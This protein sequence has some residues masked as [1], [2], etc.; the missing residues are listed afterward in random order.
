VGELQYVEVL[1]SHL[2]QSKGC[3]VVEF[4]YGDDARYAIHKFNEIVF[5]GRPIFVREDREQD[6]GLD[7]YERHQHR[8]REDGS[9][10]DRQLFVGNVVVF[11]GCDGV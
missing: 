3:A 8:D 5:M 10:A 4:K 1:S 6:R 11:M 7:R 2:G 9:P